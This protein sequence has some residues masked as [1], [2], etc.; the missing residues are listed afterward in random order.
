M[1]VIRFV[2][3][4]PNAWLPTPGNRLVIDGIEADRLAEMCQDMEVVSHVRYEDHCDRISKELGVRLEPS[5]VNA[6][7]PF[8]CKDILIVATL[9]PGT[10]SIQYTIVWDGTAVLNEAGVL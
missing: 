3:A 9:S 1:K 2:H 7:N 6:P 8:N 4:L 5:G 10:T